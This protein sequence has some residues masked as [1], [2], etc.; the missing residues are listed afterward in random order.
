VTK[1]EIIQKVR[2]QVAYAI[3]EDYEGGESIMKNVWEQLEGEEYDVADDELKR[4][5]LWL[6]PD[7]KIKDKRR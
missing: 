3:N 7:F 4:I 5:I 1:E 6:V 2:S